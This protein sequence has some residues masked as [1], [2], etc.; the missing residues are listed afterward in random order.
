MERTHAITSLFVM[1]LGMIAVS[2]I[3]SDEVLGTWQGTVERERGN[4]DFTIEFTMDEDGLSG[5]F[6]SE[7]DGVQTLEEVAYTNGTLSFERIR[8][9]SEGAPVHLSYSATI[10][11][12]TMSVTETTRWGDR[13][14]TAKRTRDG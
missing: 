11:G 14:F 2:A 10:E 13:S 8:L 4:Y 1:I 9:N 12:D 7:L 5:T 3:A 6:T